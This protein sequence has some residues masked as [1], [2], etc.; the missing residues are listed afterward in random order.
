M[1]RDRAGS[2]AQ[3]F[4]RGRLSPADARGVADARGRARVVGYAVLHGLSGPERGIAYCDMPDGSRALAES[5]DLDWLHE[6]ER[7][8]LCGAEVELVADGVMLPV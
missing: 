7:D 4:C 5:C 1:R 6:I 2:Q 3:F 8:E